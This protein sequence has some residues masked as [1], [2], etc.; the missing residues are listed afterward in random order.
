MWIGQGRNEKRNLAAVSDLT[1]ILIVHSLVEAHM[2][3]QMRH[4]RVSPNCL[5]LL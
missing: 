2:S 1:G 3:L 4:L 5:G